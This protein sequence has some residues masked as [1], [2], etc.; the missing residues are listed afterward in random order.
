MRR[1]A[2]RYFSGVAADKS[3]EPGVLGNLP[4]SRPGHRSDK[5]GGGARGAPTGTSGSAGGAASRAKASGS[6]S[7]AKATRGAA[8]KRKSTA[9]GARA[10]KASD[11]AAA[12]R[13]RPAPKPET[14]RRPEPGAPR[15]PEPAA[16]RSTD[17]L[18]GAVRLAGK[19]AEAGLRTAG[20]LL[21]RLP[22]R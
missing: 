20:D 7:R 18:T 5:R 17:P 4:R 11:S 14:P 12:R 19:V 10:A 9:R 8:A 6:S 2:R 16:H 13:A 15:S 21:R 3:D 22:G 1:R